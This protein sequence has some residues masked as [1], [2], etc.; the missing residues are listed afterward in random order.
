ML[1]V[2]IKA[3]LL[4]I[5]PMV[6][7]AA[8]FDCQK[9]ST[10]TEKRI[11]ASKELSD[12]DGMLGEI[13][14]FAQNRLPLA[15]E[16]LRADQRAWLRKR[17]QC[18]SDD[19]VR[20]VYLERLAE[21]ESFVPGAARRPPGLPR[22]PE[23]VEIFPAEP[24]KGVQENKPLSLTGSIRWEGQ[25]GFVIRT[26]SGKRAS[27]VQAMF[28]DESTSG[29]TSYLNDAKARFVARGYEGQPDGDL[30]VFARSRCVYVY[31]LPSG[32]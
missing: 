27:L 31:R 8:S 15:L 32:H 17:N 21:L 2:F 11:C 14:G 25:D 10:P 1:Q 9:A 22:V 23:L 7:A 29:L 6:A 16:C 4:A 18:T 20:R 12:L 3:L 24:I 5:T 26:D 30:T 13:Y 28:A 19:C